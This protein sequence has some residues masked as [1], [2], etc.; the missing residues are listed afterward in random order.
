MAIVSLPPGRAA[1]LNRAVHRADVGSASIRHETDAPSTPHETGNTGSDPVADSSS[2]RFSR[3]L[4]PSVSN[5]MSVEEIARPGNMVADNVLRDFKLIA[6]LEVD[7]CEIPIQPGIDWF[8]RAKGYYRQRLVNAGRLL[9][10]DSFPELKF[11]DLP[12]K[13]EGATTVTGPTKAPA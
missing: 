3:S 5:R 2:E 12:A 8:L 13:T 1:A 11:P 4:S 7:R 9:S 10:D 6:V